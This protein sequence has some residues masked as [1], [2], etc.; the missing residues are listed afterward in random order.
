MSG[1]RRRFVG[2]DTTKLPLSMLICSGASLMHLNH[3]Y[4]PNSVAVVDAH[5]FRNAK[6]RMEGHLIFGQSDARRRSHHDVHNV[7]SELTRLCRKAIDC[8]SPGSLARDTCT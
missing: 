4:V 8:R 1:S 6:T 3:V 2:F 5:K 7:E